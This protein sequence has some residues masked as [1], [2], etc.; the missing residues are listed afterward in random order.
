MSEPHLKSKQYYSDLYDRHTVEECRRIEKFF[1]ESKKPLPED[2]SIS[3]EDAAAAEAYAKKLSL[4]ITKGERY[5]NRN[6]T[7]QEWMDKDKQRDDF[8]A[9]AQAPEDI[10]CLTCRNRMKVTF[11]DLWTDLEKPDRVLFMYDCPNKC[12]PRRAFFSDGEEWRVKPILCL[13]CSTPLETRRK[14]DDKKVITTNSCP[15]CGYTETDEYEWRHAKEKDDEFDADFAK[16]RDRFCLT[17]EQG[18]EYRDQKWRLENMGKIVKEWEEKEKIL[19]EKLKANPK[20]FHLEGRGY[21]CFICGHSI[22]NEGD[23]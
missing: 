11:K 15:K 18:A 23:N 1:T 8:Y 2:G 22:M 10:R 17:D 13:H 21:R 9:S 4:N 16:D 7:I 14:D 12:L 20:G 19:Q 6:K 3:E 5:L